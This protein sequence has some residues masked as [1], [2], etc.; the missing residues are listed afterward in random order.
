MEK[1]KLHRKLLATGETG[2]VDSGGALTVA[3][4]TAIYASTAGNLT[5]LNNGAITTSGNNG[6]EAIDSIV[7]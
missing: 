6:N 4:V 2:T 7:W 5:I 1:L 3:D